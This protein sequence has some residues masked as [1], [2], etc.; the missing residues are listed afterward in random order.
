VTR[1]HVSSARTGLILGLLL[2]AL[3]I[4]GALCGERGGGE[5]A[6][7]GSGA[8]APVVQLSELQLVKRKAKCTKRRSCRKRA[9]RSRGAPPTDANFNRLAMCE[10]HGDIRAVGGSGKYLGAFQQTRSSW[11]R[12][13][14]T[15]IHGLGILEVN[16]ETQRAAAREQQ[17]KEGWG[18]WPHCSR[19]LGLR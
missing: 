4:S 3:C 17:A 19:K 7:T 6:P 1:H 10:S 5:R 8:P 12:F 16:Y 13:G 14:S 15:H 2:A 9:S 18:P 11:S